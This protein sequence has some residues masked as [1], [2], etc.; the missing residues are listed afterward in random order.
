MMLTV[1]E[2]RA[3]LISRGISALDDT[4][5]LSIVIGEGANGLSAYNL[6]SNIITS[7]GGSLSELSNCSISKLRMVESL[8]VKR[9]VQIASAVELGARVSA[10]E[11]SRISVVSSNEDIIAI[12]RPLIG[13]LLHEEMWVVYLSSANTILDKVRVSQ[14]GVRGSYVDHKIIVKRAIEL[15]AC[16]MVL[17][18]NHPSGGVQPSEED[19][20]LTERLTK[21]AALFDIILVDHMI[22]TADNSFS[23]RNSSML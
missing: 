16:S 1:K 4:E 3:K 6:S 20:T 15:L 17:V 5:L 21:A 8:G 13:R 11:S 22:I 10:S 18:H 12:F 23:F 7:L 2:I 14:G 19:I 9:A